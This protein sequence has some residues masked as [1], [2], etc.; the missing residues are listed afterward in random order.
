[1]ETET[2]LSIETPTITKPNREGE[3]E[4][5]PAHADQT[6]QTAQNNQKPSNPAED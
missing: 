1:M 2:S 6:K 3:T 4:P 5:Q